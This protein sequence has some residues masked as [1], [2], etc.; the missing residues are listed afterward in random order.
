MFVS[1][2]EVGAARAAGRGMGGTGYPHLYL[3]TTSV[4]AYVTI[5]LNFI[6]ES[7]RLPSLVCS[8]ARDRCE[9]HASLCVALHVSPAPSASVP[10]V[11]VETV[12]GR[13]SHCTGPARPPSLR[14][15]LRILSLLPEVTI[16]TPKPHTANS[17]PPSLLTQWASSEYGPRTTAP[18]SCE[19]MEMH[20]QGPMVSGR[21]PGD[22][23]QAPQ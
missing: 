22:P 23:E 8:V 17:L 3:T 16:A 19:H 21:P 20:V 2:R 1:F 11:K 4:C 5:T 6:N 9:A 12:S 13:Q 10:Q 7:C 14:S 15:H 18:V